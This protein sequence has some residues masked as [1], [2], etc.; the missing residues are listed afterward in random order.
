[1][2]LLSGPL[3]MLHPLSGEFLF[4]LLHLVIIVMF[5]YGYLLIIHLA[6]ICWHLLRNQRPWRSPQISMTLH[7]LRKLRSPQQRSAWIKSPV[8]AVPR[9]TL[10]AWYLKEMQNHWFLQWWQLQIQ[11]L[12]MVAASSSK[13]AA[14]FSHINLPKAKP[15]SAQ[16]SKWSKTCVYALGTN[17]S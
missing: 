16:M 3:L 14:T 13:Y 15:A 1:M 17:S 4:M 11:K 5:A 6:T 12:K 2:F 10:V 7:L 8:K 9:F